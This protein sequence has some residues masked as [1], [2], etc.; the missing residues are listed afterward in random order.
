MIYD[1]DWSLLMEVGL[2]EDDVVL[3]FF[4]LFEA[5]DETAAEELVLVL[6]EALDFR[7]VAALVDAVVA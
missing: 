5:E 7:L 1:D 3:S 6:V 2:E 4:D